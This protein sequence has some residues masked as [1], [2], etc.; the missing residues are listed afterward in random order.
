MTVLATDIFATKGLEYIIAIIFLFLLVPFWLWLFR[1]PQRATRS[2][3][4]RV[5]G[6]FDV[7][8][9]FGM[10][11]GHA[12][13]HP[14]E[15]RSTYRVGLDDFAGKLIGPPDQIELPE[16]G[17][18]IQA[19]KAAWSLRIGD[20]LVPMLAP[21]SGRVIKRNPALADAPQLPIHAPYT[22]GWLIEVQP[23]PGD[24]PKQGLMLGERAVQ[25]M[26]TV[27]EQLRSR[28]GMSLGPVMQDG[29]EI[30][31]GFAR[32]LDHEHWDQVAA[33]FLTLL[34]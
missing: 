19:G 25:W 21:I 26:E 31:V 32:E 13:A 9:G 17:A 24:D 4:T 16:P 11:R 2:A 5:A 34:D 28:M 27:A 8:L 29:G 22:E 14:T 23:E 18:R 15:G 30:R 20:T 10:H 33:E 7:Q 6:W 1:E 3:I 12:W